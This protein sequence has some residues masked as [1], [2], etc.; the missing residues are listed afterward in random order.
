MCI[1]I[2]I[3]IY[4]YTYIYI[5]T[6]ASLGLTPKVSLSCFRS[7]SSLPLSW[8]DTCHQFCLVSN[9]NSSLEATKPS[10]PP[11]TGRFSLPV[12]KVESPTNVRAVPFLCLNDSKIIHPQWC[13]VLMLLGHYIYIYV[14]IYI[15]IYIHTHI[16]ECTK[17]QEPL[18]TRWNCNTF[19]PSTICSK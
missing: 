15:I 2:Y 14:C 19:H 8:V 6:S 16:R 10:Q 7:C 4:I 1:Y 9:S 13:S 3:H 5:Y 17:C 18:I 12:C 11:Y